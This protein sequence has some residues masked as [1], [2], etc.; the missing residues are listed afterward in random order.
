MMKS[1]SY[2]PRFEKCMPAKFENGAYVEALVAS[3]ELATESLSQLAK[4]QD[5]SLPIDNGEKVFEHI[6]KILAAPLV[7]SQFD[8]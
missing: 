6:K 3:I 2:D 8:K 5:I 1:G 4:S 7:S